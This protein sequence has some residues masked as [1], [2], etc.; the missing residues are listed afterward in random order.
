MPPMDISGIVPCPPMGISPDGPEP[1][2]GEL[3]MAGMP[4][5]DV[6]GGPPFFG[7]APMGRFAALIAALIPPGAP[8]IGPPVGGGTTL[9]CIANPPIGG[10]IC[11]GPP[12][13]RNPGC[14]G[15]FWLCIICCIMFCCAMFG[16]I[17]VGP[18]PFA[19]FCIMFC[20]NCGRICCIIAIIF[21]IMLLG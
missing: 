21:C 10:D 17:G 2:I 16:P 3:V 5:K 12:L 8:M 9:P 4:P 19:M 1:P 7:V 14:I 20:I 13:P 6:G 15:R 18:L 11:G